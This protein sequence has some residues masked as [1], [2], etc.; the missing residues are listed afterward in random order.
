MAKSEK[1]F[2]HFKATLDPHNKFPFK[3]EQIIQACGY[4]PGWAAQYFTALAQSDEIDMS[5]REHMDDMYGFGMYE[6][7]QTTITD[8]LVHQYPE[9][10]D[11]Y[12]LLVMETRDGDG[13]MMV[14]YQHGLVSFRESPEDE[15]F[16]TRMD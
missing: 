8:D 16:S 14:Q 13:P 15:W 4:L 5:L 12:P 11:L 10:P 7:K 1:V 9:D 3:E 6:S 2:E